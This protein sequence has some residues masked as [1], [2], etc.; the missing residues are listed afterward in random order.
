[1]RPELAPRT[2]EVPK[3]LGVPGR[4]RESEGVILGR[5]NLRPYLE[6]AVQTAY[7]AGR[8]TLGHFRTEAARPEFKPDGTPVTAAD[9]EAERLADAVV[10]FT[11]AASFAEHGRKREWERLL[12]A[13]GAGRGWSDAYG[14]ALVATG[15]A[16]LMLDPVVNYWD[17]GPFPPILREAGGYFGDWS[18]DETIY[19]GEAISTTQRLLPEVLQLIREDRR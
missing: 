17:C 16:E 8:L 2:A 5:V 3:G 9:K 15:R 10:S 13:A 14:H 1:M 4:P 6:L 7:E 19:G 12:A 18:G 11:D